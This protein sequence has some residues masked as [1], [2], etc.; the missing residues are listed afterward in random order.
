M[1]ALTHL[2]P[3]FS[4]VVAIQAVNE[5]I[6]DS[7]KTPGYGDCTFP[8]VPVFYLTDDINEVQ[9]HFVLTI[10]AVEAV[11]GIGLSPFAERSSDTFLSAL[12]IQ[13]QSNSSDVAVT[14]ALS[15]SVDILGDLTSLVTELLG[16]AWW[17]TNREP[18]STA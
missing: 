12:E 4:D 9:K 8:Y 11:L 3:D 14:A 7:T 2:D 18:L 5:P 17:G 16:V 13:T 1:T 15:A 10:R 6:G